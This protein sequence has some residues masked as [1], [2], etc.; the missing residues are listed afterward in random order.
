MVADWPG[1]LMPQYKKA[2]PKPVDN[3]VLH[4]V[5]YPG[6][7]CYTLGDAYMIMNYAVRY[8]PTNIKQMTTEY[9]Y[10]E[11]IIDICRKNNIQL[12]V[13]NMPLG[14]ANLKALG[15]QAY[16]NYLSRINSICQAKHV[17]VLDLDIPPYNNGANFLDTVHLNPRGSVAVFEAITKSFGQSIV[18]AQK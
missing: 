17:P 5:I 1:Q 6:H 15:P 11:R 14:P 3:P 12:S 13:V 8:N 18:D 2:P 7:A 9:K 10:F 16:Q 4:D